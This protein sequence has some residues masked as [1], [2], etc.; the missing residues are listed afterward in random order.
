MFYPSLTYYDHPASDSYDAGGTN[1]IH[2]FSEG[3][4]SSF[5]PN[6]EYS[7]FVDSGEISTSHPGN[8]ARPYSDLYPEDVSPYQRVWPSTS[9]HGS[10]AIGGSS[11]Y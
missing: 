2:G 7:Y 10:C 11:G 3:S 6:H 9:A 4:R 1:T 5:Y 8:L